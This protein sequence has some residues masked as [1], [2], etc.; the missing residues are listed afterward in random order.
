M[1]STG[2]MLIANGDDCLDGYMGARGGKVNKRG[3]VL[4]VFKSSLGENSGGAIGV[5]RGELSGVDG[6]AIWFT[7]HPV[8]PVPSLST[9]GLMKAEKKRMESEGNAMRC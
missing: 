6:G 1:S 5:I 4:G 3:V 7:G 9:G 8:L 2:S